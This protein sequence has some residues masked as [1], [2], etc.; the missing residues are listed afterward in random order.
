[1]KHIRNLWSILRQEISQWK[2]EKKNLLLGILYIVMIA[3]LFYDQML[4][5]IVLSP[6][7]FYWM[8]KQRIRQDHRKKE[9]IR[10]EFREMLL[11]M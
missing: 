3:W 8:R 2:N 7:L 5:V 1:M 11:S 9:Q 10:E 6:F 4:F